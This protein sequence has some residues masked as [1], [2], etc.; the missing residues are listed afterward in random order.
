M[1]LLPRRSNR[2]RGDTRIATISEDSAT[3]AAAFAVIDRQALAWPDSGPGANFAEK[4][5]LVATAAGGFFSAGG[6]TG[7]AGVSF[8]IT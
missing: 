1:E 6:G 7:V 2:L 5:Y 8:P 4:L 3:L